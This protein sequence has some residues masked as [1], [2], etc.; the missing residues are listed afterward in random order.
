[1]VLMLRR[2]RNLLGFAIAFTLAHSITLLASALLPGMGPLWLPRVAGT[3]MALFIIY[4]AL[5]SVFPSTPPR[6]RPLIAVAS[7]MVFGSG[8][9]FFLEPLVQYGGEHPMTAAI[10]VQPRD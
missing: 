6:F 4:L 3:L 8:F 9:W 10:S 2:K 5:E 7:G 1:M